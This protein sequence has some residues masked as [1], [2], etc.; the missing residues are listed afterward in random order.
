MNKTRVMI[1]TETD[2]GG[3]G[4]ENTTATAKGNRKLEDFIESLF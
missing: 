4:G 1:G 2:I 3:A